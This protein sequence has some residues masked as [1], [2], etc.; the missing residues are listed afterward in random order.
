MDQQHETQIV[1]S[2]AVDGEE[3]Y[4]PECGRRLLVYWTPSF[5][6]VVLDRGDD[7]AVHAG[8]SGGLSLSLPQPIVQADE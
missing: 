8:S 6:R 4:C 2:D 7:Y 3:W 1:W 5:K